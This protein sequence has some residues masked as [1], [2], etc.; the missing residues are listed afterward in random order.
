MKNSNSDYFNNQGKI[1]AE[2]AFIGFGEVNTPKEIIEKKCLNAKKEL[3]NLGINFKCFE[4]VSDDQQG[5]HAKKTIEVL[6]KIN[7]DFIV[8]CI[9]GWIPTWAVLRVVNNFSYKPMLLW[10]LSGY[11]DDKNKLYTTADQAGTTA[12]RKVF[13]DLNYNFKYIYNFAG[14]NTDIEKIKNFAIAVKTLNKLKS[15]KIG[16]MGYRDMN[17]Y[18]TF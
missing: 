2:A 15:S 5:L 8:V 3:E 10:G 16:M 14:K 4:I 7:F 13:E 12:T 17:L 18:S 1:I 9:A 6:Q 11:Y